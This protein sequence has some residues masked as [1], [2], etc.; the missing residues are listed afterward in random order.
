MSAVLP[1]DAW[2]CGTTT[3][4]VFVRHRTLAATTRPELTYQAA[5]RCAM[6]LL[7]HLQDRRDH[8]YLRV[9]AGGSRTVMPPGR[10]S[11]VPE[12]RHGR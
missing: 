3:R 5:R 6:M 11:N 2:E 10:S 7:A 1:S 12:W 9:L 4:G 8:A